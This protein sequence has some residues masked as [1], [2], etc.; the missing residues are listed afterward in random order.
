MTR[1]RRAG[2]ADAEA[3][4]QVHLQS[5]IET[6]TGLLPNEVIHSKNA[7]ERATAWRNN[8]LAAATTEGAHH[9]VLLAYREH[10]LVAFGSFGLQRNQAIAALWF[11]AEFSAIYVLQ[12]AQRCGIGR[13]LM[14][15]MAAELLLEGFQS[16]T[17]IVLREN[18][19]AREF[20]EHIGA[21]LLSERQESRGNMNLPEVVY[22]WSDLTRMVA[23]IKS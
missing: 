4:A 9:H 10:E 6:Y 19:P 1:Y 7:A 3:I 21:S 12:C 23:P 18:R 5:W 2:P 13:T 14:A 15:L 20:Y 16:A 22:A 11:A 8:L 17:L